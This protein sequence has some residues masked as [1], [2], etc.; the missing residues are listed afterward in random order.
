M[1]LHFTAGVRPP[2]RLFASAVLA[3]SAALASAQSGGS[4]VPTGVPTP[5]VND[6][7]ANATPLAL[8]SNPA[9]SSNANYE[10]IGQCNGG[11]QNVWFTFAPPSDG[12]YS[13]TITGNSQPVVAGVFLGSCAALQPL[14]CPFTTAVFVPALSAGQTYYVEV[15]DWQLTGAFSL[16]VATYLPPANDACANAATAVVGSNP[17]TV[18]GASYD[19][20]FDGACNEDDA[21][22]WFAFTPPASGA[23]SFGISGGTPI[24]GSVRT[25]ACGALTPLLC[26]F[27]TNF[28]L[29]ALTAGVAYYVE[30]V[31]WQANSTFSLDV[32]VVTPAP[33]D[34]C[35][36]ALPAVVGANPVDTS[37]ATYVGAA[38]ICNEGDAN[39]WL[40]FVPP[41]TGAYSF[42]INGSGSASVASVSSGTCGGLTTLACPFSSFAAVDALTAGQT[43]FVEIGDWQNSGAFTVDIAPYAR[44]V[45]GDSC[46]TALVANVGLNVGDSTGATLV[47]GGGDC[48]TGAPNVWYAFTP[49]ATS[50]YSF[51]MLGETG[52]EIGGVFTGSC[53][54]LS[55]LACV[56]EERGNVGAL[57]AGVTYYVEIVDWNAAGA[58]TLD[59]S[60]FV[61]AAND[62]CA[63]ALPA[64]IGVTLGVDGRFATKSPGAPCDIGGDLWYSFTPSCSGLFAFSTC[65]LT[66]NVN[67]NDTVIVLYG[68]CGATPLACNDDSCG[69]ESRL[70]HDLVAGQ[71]YLVRVGGYDGEIV[72]TGLRIEPVEPFVISFAVAPGSVTM[73]IEH[74][75]GNALYFAPLTFF[76]GN[77]PQGAFFGIDISFLDLLLQANAGAPFVGAL[78]ACGATTQGPYLG[79]PPGLTLYSVALDNLGAPVIRASAPTTFTTL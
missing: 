79:V 58:F 71:T 69:S 1:N 33:G 24:I 31:D 73:S 72:V 41:T 27:S 62:D 35:S 8:G 10:S 77:Y 40:T 68:A 16:D 12:S 47:A 3:L 44:A 52:H 7:C 49:P 29:D 50:A 65:G 37:T 2:R 19:G 25:G 11:D 64:Q 38:G 30:I 26:P 54:S 22:V 6:T 70:I 20:D 9:T 15:S 51:A 46:S 21:N 76:A 48:N 61:P 56:E 34:S 45:P 28:R 14:A 60:P 32:A 23:Y 36:T 57:T 53:G 78:D 66:Q 59:V 67:D 43:Y 13:F 55:P 74:G 39:V 18:A 17:G 75:T 63:G 4:V 42:A 5:P